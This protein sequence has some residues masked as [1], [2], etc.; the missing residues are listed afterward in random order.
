MT[1]NWI[2]SGEPP[3]VA[4]V[5]AHAASLRVL[6]SAFPKISIN[7]GNIFASI[8]LYKKQNQVNSKVKSFKVNFS[9]WI[10]WRLPAVMFEIVQHASLRILSFGDV[11]KCTRHCITEQFKTICV[12]VSS[13]VTILPT[14][15]NAPCNFNPRSA[16]EKRPNSPFYFCTLMYVNTYYQIIN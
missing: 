9:T 2:C 8:T 15:R 12:C 4:F 10:C 13:P 1:R 3:E 16:S 14:A 11:N 7:T 5:K 6:N